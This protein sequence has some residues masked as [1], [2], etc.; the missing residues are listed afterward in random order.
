MKKNYDPYAL[1]APVY[2]VFLYPF[3]DK[4]RH[5]LSFLAYEYNIKNILDVCCGTGRQSI[6]L[7]KKGIL[8][9]G[10][11]LS[12]SMLNIARAKSPQ[13]IEYFQEDAKKM[14][15]ADNVFEAAVISF[16]LH[17]KD[18]YDQTAIFKEARRVLQPGAYIFLVDFK[19]PRT[20]N[21]KLIHQLIPF[22]ERA[23]GKQHYKNYKNFIAKGGLEGFI[24]RTGLI[25]VEKI[26]YFYGSIGLKMVTC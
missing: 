15:F 4:I 7:N 14:H 19:S 3:L 17:E 24:I 5:K 12:K 23:G 13:S 10:I 20:R 2:D 21:G 11:D 1:F 25:E 22:I 26:S 6:L 8:V 16:A 18:E 9:T